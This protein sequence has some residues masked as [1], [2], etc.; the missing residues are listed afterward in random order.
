MRIRIGIDLGGTKIEYA[1]LDRNGQ[2]LDRARRPTPSAYEPTLDA[3]TELVRDVES[4]FGPASVGVGMPGTI[5]PST[6]IVKNANRQWLNG[7]TFLCDLCERLDREV[8]CAND[9]DCLVASEARDG[10]GASC[11]VVFAAILGTGCGAGVAVGGRAHSGANGVAGEWGHNALPWPRHD[12]YPG[13]DCY[14]GCQGCLETWLSGPALEADHERCEGRQGSAREIALAAAAGN[15]QA[16]AALQRWEDR[17][18]RGLAAIINVL[19]PDVIVLGGGLSNIDRIY[20]TLPAIIPRYVFGRECITPIRKALHG[21]ASGVRG[22]A[23][24]W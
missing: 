21:D 11:D 13:P 10:A 17:L 2:E 23:H 7:R 5:V 19:D 8:R 4:N 20:T 22:A 9:A 15:P 18:A 24:L 12:E 3:L 1:V 16:Q 14:C 6:G